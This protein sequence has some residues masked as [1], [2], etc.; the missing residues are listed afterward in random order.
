MHKAVR[1][2]TFQPNDLELNFMNFPEINR[3]LVVLG[4]G[5]LKNNIV[6]GSSLWFY[7]LIIKHAN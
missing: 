2:K 6:K 1:E 4:R 3:E 7:L 5:S